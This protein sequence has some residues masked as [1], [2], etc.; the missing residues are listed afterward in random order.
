M[1]IRPQLIFPTFLW[2]FVS[3]DIVT[4]HTKFE[5]RSNVRR[6]LKQRQNTGIADIIDTADN[7]NLKYRYSVLL[8]KN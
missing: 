8:I 3:I 7:V 1:A 5:V 6:A 4:V 2:T